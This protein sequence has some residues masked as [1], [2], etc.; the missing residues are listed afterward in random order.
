MDIRNA[1]IGDIDIL[2]KFRKQQLIDEGIA[3]EN[4]VDERFK[5]YFTNAISKNSIIC[6]LAIE[7]GNPVATCGL[8][9]YQLPP[10]YFST[11][12][13]ANI[14]NVYTIKEYRRKGIA[15]ML[16]K[17]VIDEAKSLNYSDIRLHASADGRPVY[18]KFGFVDATGFMQLSIK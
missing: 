16:L 2:V 8:Y 11:G 10:S 18:E 5:D 7:D 15:S 14:I 3:P 1:N 4:N 13:I 12:R 6:F 17:K 9:F